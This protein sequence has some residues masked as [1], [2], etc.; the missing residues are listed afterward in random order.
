MTL[1]LDVSDHLVKAE[2]YAA[3][4]ERERSP[5]PNPENPQYSNRLLAADQGHALRMVIYH[6][7]AAIAGA[8]GER[9]R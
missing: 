2:G 9:G 1:P 5:R 6:G 8:I 4:L 3:P 7:L